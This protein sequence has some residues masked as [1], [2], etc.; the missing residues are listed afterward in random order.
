MQ[1]MLLNPVERNIWGELE[2][3]DEEPSEEI[4][5]EPEAPHELVLDEEQAENYRVPPAAPAVEYRP[6]ETPSY[7]SDTPEVVELRKNRR[8]R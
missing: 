5:P 2:P 8:H 7:I 3:D 6:A 4:A 1:T